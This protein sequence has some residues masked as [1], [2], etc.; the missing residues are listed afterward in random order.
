MPWRCFHCT[1]GVTPNGTCTECGSPVISKLD[2]HVSAIGPY[3]DL[4]FV[5]RSAAYALYEAS[6]GRLQNRVW[7]KIAPRHLWS[8]LGR[9]FV[10]ESVTHADVSQQTELVARMV[11]I[12]ERPVGFEFGSVD[13]DI[14][15]IDHIAGRLVTD[16]ATT[17]APRTIAQAAL[18]LLAVARVLRRRKLT[19]SHRGERL[20]VLHQLREFRRQEAVDDTVR[21]VLLSLGQL[22]AE[23]YEEAVCASERGEVKWIAERVLAAAGRVIAQPDIKQDLDYR[24]ALALHEWAELRHDS[25]EMVTADSAIDEVQS[26]VEQ[27]SSPWRGPLV[28][29]RFNDAYNAQTLAPWFVPLLLV[30]PEGRWLARLATGGP[31]V[32]TGMRG[33]GKTMLLRALQL[34]ARAAIRHV[35]NE[36]LADAIQRVRSDNYVGLYVSC[37][38][39]LDASGVP[40][41][42]GPTLY[43]RLFVAYALEAVR[44]LRH[45]EDLDPDDVVPTYYRA[46]GRAVADNVEGG[47][48]FATSSSVFHLERELLSS[49]SASTRDSKALTLRGNPAQAFGALASV[50]LRLSALWD[51][52]RVFF[53]LDDLSTRYLTPETAS[54]L[55][56]QLLFQSDRCAFKITTERQTLEFGFYS[57]GLIERA[58]LG[59]DYELFD[60]GNEVYERMRDRR[61]GRDFLEGILAQRA[62]YFPLHPR[63]A[64]RDVLGDEH[65]EE[66]ARSIAE[67]AGRRGPKTSRAAYHGLSALAAVC[68][69]DIGDVISIYDLMLSRSSRRTEYPIP[70]STQAECFQEFCGRR[71]YDLARRDPRLKDIALAFAQASHTLLVRSA[72][73]VVEGRERRLRQ[74]LRVHVSLSADDSGEHAETLRKLVDAGVFILAGSIEGPR[75]KR[76]DLAPVY[77]YVLTFR[78]LL[79]LWALIGLSERDRF[80][81]NGAQLKAWMTAGADGQAILR[82]NLGGGT[83][84]IDASDFEDLPRP[85][86]RKHRVER[87]QMVLSAT[88][89]AQESL[90]AS[91]WVPTLRKMP[92]LRRSDLKHAVIGLG[93]EERSI[94]SVS[95]WLK[96]V[97]PTSVTVVEY[98]SATSTRH[99]DAVRKLLAANVKHV[100]HVSH[101]DVLSTRPPIHYAPT[102]VDVTALSAG[103]TFGVLRALLLRKVPIAIMYT[104]A[105]VYYPLDEQI[106]PILSGEAKSQYFETMERLRALFSEHAP[107]DVVPLLESDSDESRRRAL[108]GFASPK[109]DRLLTV[110]ADREFDAIDVV[111]PVSKSPRSELA[112]LVAK[113]AARNFS[114]ARMIPSDARD[115]DTVLYHLASRFRHLYV[116]EGFNV[117]MAITGSKLQAVACAAMSVVARFSQ[118]WYVTPKQYDLRRVTAGVG[119]SVCYE[120]GPPQRRPL[121]ASLERTEIELFE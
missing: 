74:Y 44:A 1:A 30:D 89:A 79:G 90:Y 121:Q 55:L 52:A 94:E 81:L 105:E 110:L 3:G 11:D 97:Q 5:M 84:D 10:A 18:D 4:K 88:Q 17:L 72:R 102:L 12:F 35:D 13:C 117:E 69:G 39:L 54:E 49:L 73:D 116:E 29:R 23:E 64:P 25:T 95:R 37:T 47:D 63:I 68:V 19:A 20:L 34:H 108:F 28:L 59:R 114:T 71:L 9:D 62:R 92:L 36:H 70:A 77:Q 60:L 22:Q 75:E 42:E 7:L 26:A 31:M 80:E 100:I 66:I 120:V 107:Y 46:L 14:A 67:S 8:S 15:V 16:E 45:L 21:C 111:V 61:S 98:D 85:S 33:C 56:S 101:Q 2:G 96:L 113:L 82:G 57:P 32:I 40:K 53:L 99:T 91:V 27:A 83:D 78:K 76:P 119:D 58:R 43:G 38:R 51:G 104:A 48:H 93:A 65:L 87:P 109:H 118:C 86:Q 6:F 115:L 24:L 106:A 50:L 112:S 41:S 103:A